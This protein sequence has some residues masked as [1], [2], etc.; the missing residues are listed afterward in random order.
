MR[1][2]TCFFLTVSK[3]DSGAGSNRDSQA[4]ARI[5][6]WTLV[7]S[8]FYMFFFMI[9]SKIL[10]EYLECDERFK[11][12]SQRLLINWGF[13]TF[14]SKTDRGGTAIQNPPPNHH[15]SGWHWRWCRILGFIRAS[16][17]DSTVLFVASLFNCKMFFINK[18]N[19]L[20]TTESRFLNSLY[21][22][23]SYLKGA[24]C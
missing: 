5:N 18:Q 8:H 12:I 14:S 10:L 16:S 20:V 6:A 4:A 1:F 15:S 19:V 17:I 9:R 11:H 13:N 2:R 3:N 22:I 7:S 24:N 21:R 23:R